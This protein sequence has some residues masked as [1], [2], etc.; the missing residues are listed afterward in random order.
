ME[1]LAGVFFVLMVAVGMMSRLKTL[2]KAGKEFRMARQER[3][4]TL[5]EDERK[6]E[7]QKDFEN[8]KEASAGV[9]GAA[10]IFGIIFVSIALFS[11]LLTRTGEFVFAGVMLCFG[12]SVWIKIYCSDTASRARHYRVF[13]IMDRYGR[14]INVGFSAIAFSC[15]LLVLPGSREDIILLLYYLIASIL[16][17]VLSMWVIFGWPH[18][19]F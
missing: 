1:E 6:K 4:G 17:Y 5:N 14:F 16:L 12:L 7:A 19:K 10:N 8:S 18:H 15:L 3:W 2:N 11:G 9:I 13:I